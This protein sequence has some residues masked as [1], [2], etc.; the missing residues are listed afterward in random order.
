M[1]SYLTDSNQTAANI[2][3]SGLAD[4]K[5]NYDL[6]ETSRIDEATKSVAQDK[7][8]KLAEAQKNKLHLL[9]S[10][11][12]Q[13]LYGNKV[14]LSEGDFKVGNSTEH[15]KN[16]VMNDM[17]DAQYQAYI[18]DLFAKNP[19]SEKDGKAYWI[20]PRTKR[21]EEY[22]GEV[23]RLYSYQAKDGTEKIGLSRGRDDEGNILPTSDVRYSKEIAKQYGLKTGWEPGEHGVDINKKNFDILLP[24]EVAT[25]AE[26]ISHG[27]LNAIANRS[28]INDGSKEMAEKKEEYGA[29]STEY[30]KGTGYMGDSSKD[31]NTNLP[32]EEINALYNHEL[33][34][35]ITDKIDKKKRDTVG[36][37]DDGRL[38]TDVKIAESSIAAFVS[39]VAN[40]FGKLS[41]NDNKD[42][43]S[44]DGIADREGEYGV[45]AGI[46]KLIE[47]TNPMKEAS[48]WEDKLNVNKTYMT[49]HQERSAE[50]KK[51]GEYGKALWETISH[52]D[53]DAA[54]SAGEMAALGLGPVGFVA[55][56]G[57]R[58][59]NDRDDYIKEHN[60]KAPT[61]LELAGW[62][63]TNTAVLGLEKLAFIAPLGRMKNRILGTEVKEGE[64]VASKTLHGEEWLS[65]GVDKALTKA[66]IENGFLRGT[67]DILSTAAS[68][69]TFE[70]IQEVLDQEQQS[71]NVHDKWLSKDEAIS[72][73]IDGFG[74]SFGLT[75]T[76]KAIDK[77]KQSIFGMSKDKSK[78]D[79]ELD[80]IKNSTTP[81]N[82][83]DLEATIKDMTIQK[84]AIEKT[85]AIDELQKINTQ[86]QDSNLDDDAKNDLNKK[87]DDLT[88]KVEELNKV[89]GNVIHAF[90]GTTPEEVETSREKA[91]AKLEELNKGIETSTTLLDEYKAHNQKI[92]ERNSSN[93]NPI[94]KK[95][96]SAMTD[97]ELINNSKATANSVAN[98]VLQT[99]EHDNPLDN[100]I[101]SVTLLNDFKSVKEELD[102]RDSFDK[103]NNVDYKDLINAISLIEDHVQGKVSDA[104]EVAL[105]DLSDETDINTISNAI[106]ESGAF[107]KL[108]TDDKDANAK[109][110]K[111]VL[112]SMLS[113]LETEEDSSELGAE[114]GDTTIIKKKKKQIVDSTGETTSGPIL[115]TSGIESANDNG[116][117][118]TDDDTIIIK[119]KKA[120]IVDTEDSDTTVI[121]KKKNKTVVDRTEE[122]AVDDGTINT[123][124][125]K[126]EKKSSNASWKTNPY[127]AA[128]M[129][130]SIAKQF[131]IKVD[132]KDIQNIVKSTAVNKQL[133][134]FEAKAKANDVSYEVLYDKEEGIIPQY[135]N[136]LEKQAELELMEDGEAKD[137]ASKALENSKKALLRFS[138]NQQT[139]LDNFSKAESNIAGKI[140]EAVKSLMTDGYKVHSPNYGDLNNMVN[141]ETVIPDSPVSALDILAKNSEHLNEVVKYDKSMNGNVD[142]SFT[143]NALDVIK[144]YLDPS[145]N[146]GIY[147]VINSLKEEVDVISKVVDN[148]FK[149][150]IPTDILAKVEEAH[151][152]KEVKDLEQAGAD[153]AMTSKVIK[154][155]E[156][157]IADL[158]S[159]L[160]DL[161]VIDAKDKAELSRINKMIETAKSAISKHIK[162]LDKISVPTLFTN[163]DGSK[164]EG[165]ILGYKSNV[166]KA[167]QALTEQFNELND[168]VKE[169]E[170]NL[171]KAFRE[172]TVDTD[173]IKGNK[174]VS[175][176]KGAIKAFKAATA[177]I[178]GN[179]AKA[180]KDYTELVRKRDL[181]ASKINELN[182]KSSKL[183]NKTVKSTNEEINNKE[184]SKSNQKTLTKMNDSKET[185]TLKDVQ[186]FIKKLNDTKRKYV[187]ENKVN[188]N[189]DRINTINKRIAELKEKLLGTNAVKLAMANSL[190]KNTAQ[191]DVSNKGDRKV[192]NLLDFYKSL[193]FR[194]MGASLVNSLTFDQMDEA[195]QKVVKPYMDRGIKF[196]NDL[197]G[198]MNLQDKFLLKD[199]PAYG[200][201]FDK[202]GNPDPTMATLLAMAVADYELNSIPGLIHPNNHAIGNMFGVRPDAVTPE[203]RAAAIKFGSFKKYHSFTLGNSIART[204][205]IN[206]NKDKTDLNLW[207][208]MI[209]DLGQIGLIDLQSRNVIENMFE[210]RM[211]EAVVSSIKEKDKAG[212]K[213]A[214]KT[215]DSKG[216]AK[217]FDVPTVKVTEKTKKATQEA[218]QKERQ[219]F[220]ADM[221]A[222]S[223]DDFAQD[224]SFT[225]PDVDS[226]EFKIRGGI[227]GRLAE[228]TVQ[229]LRN[230]TKNAYSVNFDGMK[231][232]DELGKDAVLKMLDYRTDEQVDADNTL[233][234]TAK[235]SEKALNAQLLQEVEALEELRTNIQDNAKPNK[236][237]FNWFGSKN[238]R[239]NMD[240][241][242]VAPQTMKEL[243]RWLISMEEH[244]VAFNPSNKDH[245]VGAAYSVAQAFGVDIDKLTP[246]KV[247]Y[248]FNNII[249]PNY[250]D[251]RK[252]LLS[253]GKYEGEFEGSKYKLSYDHVGHLMQAIAAMDSM[254]KNGKLN[255]ATVTLSVEF[256][257]ITNGFAQ[258]QSQFPV[259]KGLTNDHER[260]GVI[261]ERSSL[262]EDFSSIGQLIEEG[263]VVDSYKTAAL[264][265]E[266][267][268]NLIDEPGAIVDVGFPKKGEK[269]DPSI[270]KLLPIQGKAEAIKDMMKYANENGFLDAI[271]IAKEVG[272]EVTKFGRNL[273]KN[274]FMI[275]NYAASI[276]AIVE[277]LSKNI[278]M[279][280]VENA[281]KQYNSKDSTAEQK[282]VAMEMLFKIQ[283]TSKG[284]SHNSN[285][286]AKQKA[287]D[288]FVKQLSTMEVSDIKFVEGTYSK[289]M[290][291]YL[292]IGYE[293]TLGEKFRAYMDSRFHSMTEISDTIVSAFKHV[294]EVFLAKFESELAKLEN[295]TNVTHA[296]YYNLISKYSNLMPIIKSPLGENYEEGVM[297]IEDMVD[298]SNTPYGKATTQGDKE[299]LTVFHDKSG[300]PITDFNKLSPAQ[301]QIV[302]DRVNLDQVGMTVGSMRRKLAMAQKSGAV[303]PIHFIDGSVMTEFL[304]KHSKGVLGIHDALLMG[305]DNTAKKLA[306]YSEKMV[307][308]NGSYS[309]FSE[310]VNMVERVIADD[311]VDTSVATRDLYED[312]KLKDFSL[313]L[314]RAKFYSMKSIWNHMVG[315]E[316]GHYNYNGDLGVKSFERAL[317]YIPGIN[318]D[319]AIKM[320]N[321]ADTNTK[322][323]I[324]EV[325]R[326]YLKC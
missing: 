78:L 82:T 192:S 46:N 97:E 322:D 182:K 315:P 223:I 65:K 234:E 173:G 29:G 310:V 309:I 72:A 275:F 16:K 155:T 75:G 319:E 295:S 258:K 111:L 314:A 100:P 238:G 19:I 222:L 202:D 118:T 140:A 264:G 138:K 231:V 23:E 218:R 227:F 136:I 293:R 278:A 325:I 190:G 34:R 99:S 211:P 311:R 291:S 71:F 193:D 112:D 292:A 126:K 133:K 15:G 228:K 248:V 56:V 67:A 326:S 175:T 21:E 290:I 267:Y 122:D 167:K 165:T 144:K 11:E 53:M 272:K 209:Q 253:D 24:K 38:Y 184:I 266:D 40:T 39:G 157:E 128:A 294:T 277:N 125:S 152:A 324:I 179:L 268:S 230:L 106:S 127:Q 317:R 282:A 31:S 283:A 279:S 189:R 159:E 47:V 308:I 1:T 284:K 180:M 151:S 183:D 7:A 208:K 233:I 240:A 166:E 94:N 226:K 232:F 299:F 241:V 87:K 113:A 212:T 213:E 246:A 288:N 245:M 25:V 229:A 43:Y 280:L 41:N 116:V 20:N 221:E 220:K 49:K 107:D 105:N 300:K 98:I 110:G 161:K 149:L 27:R 6:N 137:T 103:E 281:F 186:T 26:G 141:T 95:N 270:F 121:S 88:N 150:D 199:S 181:V 320:F 74:M 224:Y 131:G 160:E 109:V 250:K 210:S 156:K 92:A 85:F 120:N 83:G 185:K 96:Y 35:T 187:A 101:V 10:K 55:A 18:G 90:E 132:S 84:A 89:S 251:I 297:V 307:E 217:E 259:E 188:E 13:D 63:A 235:A 302:K 142:K 154:D 93:I 104:V 68:A 54:N 176:V 162:M 44:W 5:A 206:L 168:K 198:N 287:V 286:K 214:N 42:K 73:A 254:V 262:Y 163:K 260:V 316:G 147:K 216:S 197:K 124:T 76:V 256:D 114:D 252:A 177:T 58:L 191:N 313:S 81:K 64:E 117:D 249:V 298:E 139:K 201:L 205:G 172:A 45:D 158:Q 91:K 304:L 225:E 269:P 4:G 195:A 242:K 17:T 28:Y 115:D 143:V 273:F 239:F 30:Y 70:A 61:N 306:D 170:N 123:S 129:M 2:Y 37:N 301:K 296:E 255:K 194:K 257:G 207:D 8:D 215:S 178:V 52:F 200:I 285:E 148:D 271:T 69:G 244:T 153:T 204:M 80:N 119:K 236:I 62:A 276:N 130:V 9:S 77:T 14:P 102:K 274:P 32:I 171:I 51:R 3:N 196:L 263:K 305:I 237:W 164:S 33:T 134:T 86:L 50:F 12:N 48:Y 303:L 203:M 59:N 135:K 57:N 247:S 79:N 318:S 60:G 261:S 243:Q 312:L 321:K 265:V 219:K 22:H 169:A 289:D 36:S 174:R 146:G 323:A 145:Y 108:I 66:G